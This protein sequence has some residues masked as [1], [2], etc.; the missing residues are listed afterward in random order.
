M[1]SARSLTLRSILS[2]LCILLSAPQVRAQSGSWN[3]GNGT[4]SNP[5]NWLNNVIAN[6]ANNTAT[7]DVAA[8]FTPTFVSL[9]SNRTIGN[10]VF[11]NPNNVGWTIG[12]TTTLTLSSTPTPTIAN[13]NPIIDVFINPNL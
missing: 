12:G 1:L 8:G 3:A 9:D 4:W 5:A 6:G 2:G 7:F 13:N 11:D 10:L